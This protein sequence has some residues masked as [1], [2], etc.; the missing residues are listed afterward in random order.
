M[1]YIQPTA[2]ARA[3]A[4]AR[5]SK[6]QL[7]AGQR[8]LRGFLSGA[9]LGFATS[10]A[11]TVNAQGLP[12]IAG[13]LIFPVGFVMIVVL[14]L[15]LVTGSFALVPLAVIE[16][17]SSMGK[18]GWNLL[19]VFTGNLLGG[20]VY[21]AL[22]AG[23]L[24]QIHHQPPTG[25]AALLVAAAETKTIGHA[26]FGSIGLATVFAKAILCNWMV[27][28]GMVMGMTSSSTLGKIVACWLPIVT[29]FAQGFEHSVVNMFLIPVGMML[30]AKVSLRDWWLWNQLPVT[31]G[32]LVGG[33][34]FVGLAIYV[35]YGRQAPAPVPAE[36]PAE[37]AASAIPEAMEA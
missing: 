27:C 29:F 36:A 34:L 12:P 15:E 33:F 6:M 17:R 1:D 13:A 37:T 10:L 32:N 31:L 28:M 20:V 9:L 21:A 19:L 16:K 18:A 11:F 30:G 25:M 4:V 3:M 2:V 22:L 7:S 24:T 14:S 8:L 35:A 5:S 26:K 23:V